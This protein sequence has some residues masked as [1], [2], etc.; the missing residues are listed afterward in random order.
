[1]RKMGMPTAITH[2]ERRLADEGAREGTVLAA[3]SLVG[4][5]AC[6]EDS[7]RA[8][9]AFDILLYAGLR[10]PDVVVLGRQ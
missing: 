5:K 10:R 8:R 3:A 2:I 9:L 7:T 6:V 1:M 4:D